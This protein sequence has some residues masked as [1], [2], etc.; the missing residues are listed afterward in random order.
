M[1]RIDVLTR[2][3]GWLL[4]AVALLAHLFASGGYD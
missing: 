1:S 2:R 4:A 3:P